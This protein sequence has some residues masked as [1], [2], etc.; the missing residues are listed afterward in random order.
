MPSAIEPVF[1]EAGREFE[2]S[3]RRHIAAG[4]VEYLA[5]EA[6]TCGGA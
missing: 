5:S 2:T 1:N 3:T 6:V 4:A